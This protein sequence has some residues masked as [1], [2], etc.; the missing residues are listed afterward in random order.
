MGPLGLLFLAAASHLV[1]AVVVATRILRRPQEPPAMVAWIFA[2]L[3]VPGLGAMLYWILGSHRLRRKLR[4][5]RRRV[6]HLLERWRAHV[7]PRGLRP[8]LADLPEDLAGIA[9]LGRRLAGV[10]AIGGNMVSILE[11]SNATYAALEQAL[12]DARQ[13]IHMEYY[14]WQPDDTGRHFRDLVAERA[15]A[16]VECRVLLDAVGCRRIRRDF[17]RPWLKAGVRVAFFLPLYPLRLR[18]R[19]TVHLRNHRKVVVVDGHTAFL[20]SQNIGDE[21]RGR[22]RRLSP[23]YD[24]HMRICGPAA[25]F[26][27][28]TF[29]EDWYYATREALD[30]E[31]YFTPPRQCGDCIVQVLPTGPD[32][33]VSVLAQIVFAAVSSARGTIRI[34]TPY[35]VPDLAIRMA[36]EH[37][38]YRGV[39]VRLVLPSRSDSR[40]ALWAARSFYPELLE[41]GVEIH[42]YDGG[43]LHSKIVTVDDRWCMLG[44]ANM[45]VRSFRLNFETTALIYDQPVAAGLTASIDRFCARARRIGAQQV[46][47]RPLK[48]QLKEGAARLLAPLL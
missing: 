2:V 20:G 32:Q 9:E 33:P 4:R 42:E 19:W 8:T 31:A 21:Y 16:G 45:D 44:S 38:C 18:K 25:L 34:A 40:L 6:A 7:D 23:W 17:L 24:T 27:Q 28:Q 47:H 15:R 3:F 30:R 37:A 12:R 46:W 29:A 48:E 10:P 26:A 41:A 13:H 36:L 1:L 39:R 11:E 22:L 43:V 14:I 35:F 5:R